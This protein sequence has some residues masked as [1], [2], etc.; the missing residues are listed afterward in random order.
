MQLKIAETAIYQVF[1]MAREACAPLGR[2][3]SLYRLRGEKGFGC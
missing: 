1:G 2:A 3:M